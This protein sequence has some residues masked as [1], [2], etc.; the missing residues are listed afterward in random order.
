MLTKMF[1]TKRRIAMIEHVLNSIFSIFKKD[2]V[3]LII[4]YGNR[5]G[6][7]I[8]IF[9]VISGDAEYN[10]IHQNQLDITYVGS[11]WINEMTMGLDPLLTDPILTGDIIYGDGDQIIQKLIKTRLSNGTTNYLTSKANLFLQ[12]SVTHLQNKDL[13]QAC[14][15]I[16][17]SISFYCFSKHYQENGKLIDFT[18]LI[19]H[20]PKEGNLIKKAEKMAKQSEKLITSDVIAIIN[21][22]HLL[23][24]K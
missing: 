19:V 20:Y 14:N 7:D 6:R 23:L 17:F 24:T 16:R 5:G 8:D 9:V 1:I 12:W 22:T 10:C 13:K 3:V 15:C 11:D 21:Q 18:S 2:N 4:H